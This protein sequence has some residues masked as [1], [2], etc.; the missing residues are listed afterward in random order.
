MHD[1]S[2]LSR[3]GYMMFLF[4]NKRKRSSFVPLRKMTHIEG[5]K[6]LLV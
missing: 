6:V 2:K 5:G 3:I 1:S 4:E